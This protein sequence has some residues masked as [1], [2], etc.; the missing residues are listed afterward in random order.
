MPNFKP[1]HLAVISLWAEEMIRT[2]HFYRDVVGLKLLPHHGDRPAFV[3]GRGA[4][5]VINKGQPRVAREPDEGQFPVLAFAIQDLQQAVD[6]LESHG[7]EMP[8]GIEAKA[9]TQWVKFYDPAGNLIEFA[10]FG[11]FRDS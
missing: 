7:V 4:H 1:G 5:L 10:Q 9:G 2:V 3:L 6:H 8:W 11:N